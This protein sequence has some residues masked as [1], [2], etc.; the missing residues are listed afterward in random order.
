LLPDAGNP[1]QLNTRWP[2]ALVMA[3]D[4]INAMLPNRITI[5]QRALRP[6]EDGIV[7]L[8]VGASMTAGAIS[9]G[10]YDHQGHWFTTMYKT[11]KS[12]IVRAAIAISDH[13]NASLSDMARTVTHEIAHALGH[14]SHPLVPCSCMSKAL[15]NRFSINGYGVHTLNMTEGPTPYDLEAFQ[16]IDKIAKQH[17]KPL[18]TIPD[19]NA[20]FGTENCTSTYDSISGGE[21]FMPY[22]PMAE[23]QAK[24]NIDS[25]GTCK[26]SNELSTFTMLYLFTIS[27][28]LLQNIN[29]HTIQRR[30]IPQPI[31]KVVN[32][33]LTASMFYALSKDNESEHLWIYFFLATLLIEAAAHTI[34]KYLKPSEMKQSE[35]NNQIQR[36]Q[37]GGIATLC[38][39]VLSISLNPKSPARA[40]AIAFLASSM[41]VATSQKL[42]KILAH[43]IKLSKRNHDLTEQMIKCV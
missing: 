8:N 40:I 42:G 15:P 37:N 27:L 26:I 1:K 23:I 12:Q 38:M 6:N 4:Y 28:M 2:E 9:T 29:S 13:N 21:S 34:E 24:F 33:V 3:R 17:Y 43:L 30:Q 39:M 32:N 41:G 16:T 31:I 10:I 20:L 36:L 11:Y 22:D 14:G 19:M 7:I 35:F 5:I 25:F 18:Q